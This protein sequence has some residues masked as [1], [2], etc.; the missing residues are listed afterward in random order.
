MAW[1]NFYVPFK[2]TLF[3]PAFKANDLRLVN[4]SISF[5]IAWKPLNPKFLFETSMDNL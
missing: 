1:Q 4:T 3:T 2:P 5:T